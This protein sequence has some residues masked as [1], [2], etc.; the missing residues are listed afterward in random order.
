MCRSAF[1]ALPGGGLEVRGRSENDDVSSMPPGGK[2]DG[3]RPED[4]RDEIDDASSP[5]GQL[6]LSSLL[7]LLVLLCAGEKAAR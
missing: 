2:T 7:L 4:D 3:G 6:S 1:T 5:F